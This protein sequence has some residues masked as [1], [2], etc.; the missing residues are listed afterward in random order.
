M[1]FVLTVQHTTQTSMPLAGFE[2]TILAGE[3]LQTH[4]LGRSATGIGTSWQIRTRY[5]SSQGFTVDRAATGMNHTLYVCL[6]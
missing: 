6:K 3:W 4:A 1:P 2:P 5:P